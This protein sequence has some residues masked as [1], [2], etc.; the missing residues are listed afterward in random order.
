[1]VSFWT[2]HT[3]QGNGKKFKK[4]S[5]ID[6]TAHPLRHTYSTL[7]YEAGV[8][9]K[10]A[11]VLMDHSSIVVTHNIY[12]HNRAKR[13]QETADKLNSYIAKSITPTSKHLT[14]F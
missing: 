14:N 4:E 3:T 12:T 1:M 9:E 13:M 10:D 2:N 11:Q 8:T 6:T 5:G 7:V